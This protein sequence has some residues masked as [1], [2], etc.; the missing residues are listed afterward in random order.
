MNPRDAAAIHPFPG[1][2]QL[3]W[4]A[5]QMRGAAVRESTKCLSQLAGLF[6][7]QSAYRASDPQ[8]IVYRVQWCEP[9]SQGTEGGLFW[10]VT[11]IEPG[12]VGEE[13][14]MTHGHFHQK[15]DRSEFYGCVKG[16]GILLLKNERQSWHESMRAG[17]LHY[18]PGQAAHRV[19]NTGDVPLVFW[20]CWPSDAG[21]DYGSITTD[22][23]GLRVLRGD[24][25]PRVV[26]VP[27]PARDTQ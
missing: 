11:H 14:F 23:L 20:A 16:E 8:T 5:G 22:G 7:D 19:I 18:I 17:S 25:G 13:Y 12:R 3:D 1:I 6:Q 26:A 21:H 4:L 2:A 27:A 24:T 15:R 9:V 10:G